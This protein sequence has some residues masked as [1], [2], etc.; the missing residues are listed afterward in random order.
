MGASRTEGEEGYDPEAYENEAPRH[1]VTIPQGFW[2][3]RFP[4]INIQYQAF[5]SAAGAE[6]LYSFRKPAF[7]APKHPVVGVNWNDA[8]AYCRW[9]S[10]QVEGAEVDL[11]TEAE[12]EWAARGEDGR[13]YPWGNEPP[14]NERAHFQ[15]KSTAPVGDHPLGRGPFGAEDQAGNVW[16]WCKSVYRAYEDR[17]RTDDCHLDDTPG[18]ECDTADEAPRVLRGGAWWLNPRDLRVVLRLGRVPKRWG[19]FIGF[20]LVFRS[21]STGFVP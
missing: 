2:L 20:R 19:R 15:A 7:S 11:L 16:E 3:G 8:M 21:P 1:Q 13:R 10:S 12:W 6:E 14:G 18:N 5:V 4:V 17:P 9:L